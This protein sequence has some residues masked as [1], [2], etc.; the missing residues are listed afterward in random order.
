MKKKIAALLENGALANNREFGP[1]HK[2][3][4]T[5]QR[6]AERAKKEK[7]E[8]KSIYREALNKGEKDQNLLLELFTSFEQAKHMHRFH[9]A[10]LKLR[11]YQLER[12]A[13]R[14]LK[15]AEV[16]HSPENKAV[17]KPEKKK[18]AKAAAG[19]KAGKNGGKAAVH[20]H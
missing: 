17:A 18:A 19:E 7:S 20:A 14:W 6:A 4:Q 3:H 11:A 9:R 2:A 13:E 12:W 5:A 16:P 1:L 15:Q 8:A 10:G